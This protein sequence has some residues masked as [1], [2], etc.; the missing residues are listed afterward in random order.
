MTTTIPN[1]RLGNQL[2]RN[3]AV[4]LLAEKH[5]LKVNY[6]AKDIIEQLGIE[7]FSGNNIY[8]NTQLLNDDNYFSIYNSEKL[9][10]NLNPNNNFFQT[11]EITN[12]LYN[13]LYNIKSKIIEKNPFKNRYKNNNDLF[14][15]VRLNDVSHLNP[16]IHYYLN[17]IK[18]INFDTIF[19]STDDPNHSIIKILLENPN[20]K[21]IQR[22]EIHTFQFG[23]TC[24]HILLSHGSFSAI[25]GYLSFYS[26][27]YYPEYDQNKIWY[28][29]MFSINGW[30]KCQNPLKL[31]NLLINH[32]QFI[33]KKIVNIVF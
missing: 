17:A 6:C 26:T 4:S 11:K 8:T 30:I 21:L 3:L 28:G 33:V 1:G 25:I 29:D 14:I 2:I 19:I 15:H 22:N 31:K 24:K 9:N 23:S 27:V 16:G 18:K 32:L 20:A 7:L 10:Y 12:F 5:N 13:H